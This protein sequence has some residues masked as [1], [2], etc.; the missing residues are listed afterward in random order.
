M[1]F[2]SSPRTSP[3]YLG[4]QKIK[5]NQAA[6]VTNFAPIN[7]HNCGNLNKCNQRI[8]GPGTSTGL[9]LF[10]GNRT[11]LSGLRYV[12]SQIAAQMNPMPP[13]M[14]NTGRQPQRVTIR[15]SKGGATTAPMLEPELKTPKAKERSFLGNHSAT[16]LAEPGNPPPSP[17]PR[18]NLQIP[19]PA[20]DVTVPVRKLAA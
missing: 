11:A 19:R 7:T 18:R 5:K 17:I 14:K 9:V 1:L 13:V 6:S 12:M 2:M 15:A 4:S 20:S 10:E 16:A 3:R 8:C